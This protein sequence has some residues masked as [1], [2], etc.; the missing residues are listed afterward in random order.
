MPVKKKK[1]KASCVFIAWAITC[2]AKRIMSVSSS[3]Q[4]GKVNSWRPNSRRLTREA[5]DRA[6]ILLHVCDSR[7]LFLVNI[8]SNKERS[9]GAFTGFLSP[10]PWTQPVGLGGRVVQ[11]LR[12]FAESETHRSSVASKITSSCAA[13]FEPKSPSGECQ[14]FTV[15]G[16]LFWNFS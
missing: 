6:P 12:D 16:Q 5:F 10:G 11:L 3:E 9:E 1:S 4:L 2:R 7:P 15:P 13:G 8:G 14:L